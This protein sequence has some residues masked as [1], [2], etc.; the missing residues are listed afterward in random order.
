[1][2]NELVWLYDFSLLHILIIVYLLDGEKWLLE[3]CWKTFLAKVLDFDK[4]FALYTILAN[5]DLILHKSLRSSGLSGLERNFFF[6][7][8]YLSM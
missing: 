7:E 3:L 5:T 4:F 1:M 6:S 8:I 2:Q